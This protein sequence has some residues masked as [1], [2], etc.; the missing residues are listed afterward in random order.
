MNKSYK[1]MLLLAA[2][3]F[4]IAVSVY[5]PTLN[6]TFIWDDIQLVT[7][8]LTIRDHPYSFLFGGGTYYRPFLLLS[9][10]TD[11][12][13]WHL[14]PTGYHITNILLHA[15]NSLL[16]FLAGY[17]LMKKQDY[18]AGDRDPSNKSPDQ[19]MALPFVSAAIFA[20]HPIHTESV[21][22]I[23][24]RTDLLSTLFFLLAF[25][26][27][28]EYAKEKNAKGLVLSCLFFLFSLF[29]KENAI[30]FVIVVF[31][32]GIITKIPWKRMALSQTALFAVIIIYFLFRHTVVIKMLSASPGSANAF[33]SSGI[34][35][36]NFLPF[37]AGSSGYYFEK[38]VLPFNLNLMPEIPINPMYF[39]ISLLPFVL[40]G[41]FYFSRLRLEFF[42]LTWIL[43]TLLPSLSIV[44]SQIAAPLGERYLYLP[45]V[46]FTMLS[47]LI[48]TRIKNRKVFWTIAL[49]I[50]AVFAVLTVDRLKVWEN[51]TVLW[52]DTVRKNPISVAARTNYGRALL[53]GKEPEKAKKELL[54]ALGQK[55]IM[56]EQASTILYLLGTAEMTDKNYEKAEVH[57]KD[58]I[59]T[60]PRN[61]F[62]YNNLGLLYLRM[63]ESPK[64]PGG[65]KKFLD[66]AI[67]NLKE[68]L[69]I[70]PNLL[71]A[72]F[73][74]GLC[75]LKQRDFDNAERSFYSVIE[76]DP[77]GNMS[78]DSQKLLFLIE[79]QKQNLLKKG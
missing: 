1:K 22:W 4:F 77:S 47:G 70:F 36:S 13:L 58:A 30:A 72:K 19:R 61:V 31:A 41:F 44:F 64:A 69:S 11:Y 34:S 24:G 78:I 26:S 21:A 49:S 75:Y 39:F 3:V 16:V 62:A 37:L 59:K 54:I 55:K 52:E 12:G 27:Y 18:V 9:M 48:L 74:L 2:A 14:N 20:L 38:L 53:E 25:I 46:G 57:F 23:S 29:S 28:L 50:F 15:I 35:R 40:G 60:N 8:P 32:Y 42:M 73:N 66:D 45:S 68:A 6:N 5:L 71:Q 7:N 63:S 79:L 43:A 17:L 10:A 76:S 56:A 33:F 51:D 67:S 65:E